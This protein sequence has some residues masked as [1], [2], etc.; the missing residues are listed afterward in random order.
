MLVLKKKFCGV[1]VCMCSCIWGDVWKL[2]LSKGRDR[3]ELNYYKTF[4]NYV[5]TDICYIIPFV[6]M[7]MSI[8]I[9]LLL[10]KV[11]KYIW[12]WVMYLCTEMNYNE[13]E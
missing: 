2:R 6:W 4:G 3:S 9:C 13:I 7:K 12:M 8:C 11:Q 5:K 10:C 1:C